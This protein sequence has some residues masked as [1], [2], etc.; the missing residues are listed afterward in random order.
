VRLV[1]G[2]VFVVNAGQQ[3][4]YTPTRIAE[5]FSNIPSVLWLNLD[6]DASTM[7]YESMRLSFAPK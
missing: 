4:T 5:A 7:R 1:V 6:I 3:S 2:F